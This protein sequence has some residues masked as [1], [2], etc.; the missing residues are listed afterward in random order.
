MIFR[1]LAMAAAVVCRAVVRAQDSAALALV[2][3]FNRDFQ[4]DAWNV[5]STLA[6]S[7]SF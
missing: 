6:F 4:R 5:N 2:R 7:H 1:N 3:E